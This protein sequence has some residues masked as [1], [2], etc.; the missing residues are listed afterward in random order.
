VEIGG[1]KSRLQLLRDQEA[2]LSGYYRGVREIIQNRANLSGVIGPV[3]DL[4]SVEERFL[5]A[6]ETALGPALQYIVVETEASALQ[7]IRFLKEKKLGW[8]TFLPLD[9]IRPAGSGLERYGEWRRLKGVFGKASELVAADQAYEKVVRYL[10]GQILICSDL[11]VATE[12]ARLINYSCRIISLEGDLINP[13]GAIRGGSMPRRS[14]GMPLGRRREIEE[15]E[16]E[17]ESLNKTKHTWEK[18]IEELRRKIKEA[19][20]GSARLRQR[21][22]ELDGALRDAEKALEKSASAA[23]ILERRREDNAGALQELSQEVEE[24]HERREA[25]LL[26]EKS[27]V[28]EIALAEAELEGSKEIQ[29]RGLSEKKVLDESLTAV[30]IR[31]NSLQ[32]QEQSLKNNLER[33]TGDLAGPLQE[34]EEKQREGIRF[35]EALAEIAG[36]REKLFLLLQ[37]L[38]EESAALTLE[39]Q[40]H[41]KESSLSTAALLD[42]EEQQRLN[43]SRL[44]RHEKREKHLAVE[45]GRLQTE[46]QYQL[47]RFNE[48]FG[49]GELLSPAPDF[50][51]AECQGLIG[52]LNEDIEMLGVIN[53]GAIDELAR[54]QDRIGFLTEQQD[55]LRRAELS[56]HHIIGEI[57]ERMA[58]FFDEAFTE[59]KSNL[60]EIFGELFQGGRVD[61]RLTDPDNLLE[62]GIEIVAQP[63]GK[64]L[65]NISLLSTGEKSMAAVAVIFAI[66]RYKPA[67][68]YLLDEVESSLDDVNLSRFTAYLRKVSPEAQFIL[69]THRRRTMEEADLLY[70]VTMPEEGVSTLVSLKLDQKVG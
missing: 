52:T 54:L 40:K 6:I 8:C 18:Q 14:A 43:R 2:G 20:A 28:E 15:L 41:K 55:D 70:G 5:R 53:L 12:A 9:T 22:A 34:R 29:Q 30:L 64:K 63:P 7:A 25:L 19:S 68:F 58:H 11:K 51:A 35:T 60:Q 13:G 65:Q 48:L 62:A 10:L 61:L 26:Q 46:I 39:L 36:V 66:L 49:S 47:D 3:V 17:L 37:Q 57:D 44:A 27:C 33:I 59:I 32:E 31:L 4:I 21:K 67:P 69:I 42:L 56:L 45:Q 1:V 50:D 16:R 38:R 24:L 23:R